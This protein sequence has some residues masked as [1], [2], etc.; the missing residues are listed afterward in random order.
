MT[1]SYRGNIGDVGSHVP[2]LAAAVAQAQG[3]VLELGAGDNST[4]LLHYLCR[5]LGRGLVTLE[6]NP[7]WL[8]RFEEYRG[9]GHELKL[10]ER[11]YDFDPADSRWGVAFVDCAPGE[12]RERLIRVLQGHAALIV[13]HDSERDYGAGGEYGYEHV[14]PLFKHVAEFRRFRPYT[15]VLSDERP[16]NVESCD[17]EWYPP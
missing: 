7:A 9:E 10:I 1:G 17:L 11:W 15:L 14:T 5:S 3:P 8:A 16:F 13:A 6:T 2:I 4:P 12:A